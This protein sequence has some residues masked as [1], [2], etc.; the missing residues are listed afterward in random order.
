MS[1]R[2]FFLVL[3]VPFVCQAQNIADAQENMTTEASTTLAPDDMNTTTLLTP[4]PH[5]HTSSNQTAQ[6]QEDRGESVTISNDQRTTTVEDVTVASEM[7]PSSTTEAASAKGAQNSTWGY[8]LLVLLL[9]VILILLVILY[10][11]RRA[12]RRYSF[13]LRRAAPVRNT[14]DPAGTFEAICLD[15]ED[16]LTPKDGAT[17]VDL[18][19]FPTANGLAPQSQENAQEEDADVNHLKVSDIGDSNRTI[20]DH[21]VE[22]P[23]SLM[24]RLN[25]SDKDNASPYAST[26]LLDGMELNE[27]LPFNQIITSP[28]SSS[29]SSY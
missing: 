19:V 17:P 15:E 26:D 25:N 4:S 21:P 2:L 13:D 10:L 22:T 6:T 3:A 28:E 14:E 8:I 20:P 29:S 27:L 18:S 23:D 9:L 24:L 11:L 7:V 1:F 12:S 16:Q 5:N